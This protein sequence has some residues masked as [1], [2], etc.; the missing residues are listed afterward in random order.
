MNTISQFLKDKGMTQRQLADQL[1]YD[2]SYVNQIINGKRKPTDAFR[3]RWQ[4][5]FGTRALKV[6]NGDDDAAN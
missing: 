4:E 2:L 5:A 6:L 3:W 1:D